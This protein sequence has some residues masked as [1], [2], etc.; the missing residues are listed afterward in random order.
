MKRLFGTDGVRGVIG[1]ELSPDFVLK[2]SLAIGSF[3]QEGSRVIVARDVRAGGYIY[4]SIVTG[5]LLSCGV[6]VYDCDLAPTPAVQ[7]Y[8][9]TEGFDGAVIITASHNPPQYN[10]IKVVSHDGIEISRDD[11][12]VIEE[13]FYTERFREI[14]WTK[15]VNE[16][17][18]INDVNEKYVKA[19]VEHVD[20]DLIRKAELRVVIDPAN[21]VSALT[22]PIIARELSVKAVTINGDL[23]PL[24]P[25]RDPEPTVE[26]IKGLTEVV[27]ALGADFGVAHDGDG[28]RAVFVDELG[29]VIPGDASAAI[30]IKH[31]VDKHPDAPKRVYTAVSS[32]NFIERFLKGF[33]VEFIWLKV[34]S[35]GI[36]RAMKNSG[37]ALCGYEENGGFM[38]PKHQYVRDG[39]MAFALML[40]YLASNGRRLSQLYD[41]LPKVYSI[42]TKVHMS[43]DRAEKA[44]ELIKQ[45]YSNYRS[46]T[47]DGVKIISDE[48]WFLVRPSGTEPLL[49]IIV[50]AL[51]EETA[52][53]VL[54]EIKRLVQ[55]V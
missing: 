43:R 31:L 5:G 33:G 12:E 21:S 50:E 15:L 49:R 10:G 19:I 46:I 14:N 8:T 3:F 41:E 53:R 29:R 47:I 38:Y 7:Y 22:T 42:K 48:Y 4:K 52:I 40:E 17:K 16:A 37:D 34:G 26:N 24:F 36:A 1:K 11:E 27:K 23:N 30:L 2:L 55:N 54:E 28:D 20:K 18:R 44:V 35:V 25:A 6:K 45:V 39:G 13:I 51:N 9:K 32:S